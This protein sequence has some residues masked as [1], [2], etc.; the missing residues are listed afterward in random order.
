MYNMEDLQILI[1]KF[2][3]KGIKTDLNEA[4]DRVDY[5][6]ITI[7][8][9]TGRDFSTC[10]YS[11]RDNVQDVLL[12]SKIE[13]YR[14]IKG[15]EAIWSRELKCI[16]CEIDTFSYS[17]RSLLETLNKIFSVQVE[18]G[19][20]EIIDEETEKI[21][22]IELPKINDIKILIGEST[23]EFGI[24]QAGRLRMLYRM[25]DGRIRNRT[26]VRLENINV[27]N[28]DKALELLKKITNSI[29]FQ[30]DIL[31]ETPITLVKERESII[32]RHRKRRRK[33]LTINS[34]LSIEEPK[35]E[36]DEEPMALYWY[37][38]ESSNMPLFQF[39][40]FYQVIE[41]YFPIYANMEAKHKI[42]NYIKDPRFN[43]NRDSDISK[44]LNLVKIS[45]TQS[46]GNE[47]DQ[48]K[49]TIKACV[50]NNELRIF[51][52]LDK[53]RKDFYAKNNGKSIAKQKISIENKNSDLISE[54]SERLYQIRCRI[55]HTKASEIEHDIILPYSADIK[56]IHYDIELIEFISRKILILGSRPIS[57]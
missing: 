54:I 16:E 51:L 31:L 19:E 14:F 12:D 45:S 55:V 23:E 7:K 1:K 27:D 42:Q 56:K 52:K 28:H 11:L 49:A 40:A 47:R 5:N 50:D 30:F 37:A 17:P 6:R 20:E 29:F 18:N 15:F 39:L 9:P 41:F 33:Q 26:T 24:L 34:D 10:F 8:I 53:E 44:I 4:D 2:E 21:S 25:T 22:L 35:Y 36:Y 57:I 43:A 46:I 3:D 48:M 38:K 32:E 13:E